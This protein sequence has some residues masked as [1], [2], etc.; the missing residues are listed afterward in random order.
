VK[1]FGPFLF[2]IPIIL[3]LAWL[4]HT[5]RGNEAY[6]LSPTSHVLSILFWSLMFCVILGLNRRAGYTRPFIILL[7]MAGFARCLYRFSTAEIGFVHCILV[8][9]GICLITTYAFTIAPPVRRKV[10]NETKPP[11]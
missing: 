10:K 7:A 8:M 6:H 1:K 11:A 5:L 3:L 9:V 2:L 4:P